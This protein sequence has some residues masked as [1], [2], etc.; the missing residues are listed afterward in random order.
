MK[1]QNVLVKIESS[2]TQIQSPLK[3]GYKESYTSLCNKQQNHNRLN[4]PDIL[5]FYSEPLIYYSTASETGRSE[6][7][8]EKTILYTAE[9]EYQTLIQDLKSAEKVVNIQKQ[10]CSI[11]HLRDLVFDTPK[12]LHLSCKGDF[13]NQSK[14][15][16]L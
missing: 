8:P 3:P 13:C 9:E 14:K 12:V 4:I 5:F 2:Y 1:K 11:D 16:Y 7:L 15:F 10:F 6:I